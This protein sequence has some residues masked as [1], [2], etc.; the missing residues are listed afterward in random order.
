MNRILKQVMLVMAGFL[1]VPAMAQNTGTQSTTQQ[2]P[3]D[4]SRTADDCFVIRFAS[5]I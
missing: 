1:A 2:A 4:T 5:Q 3:P